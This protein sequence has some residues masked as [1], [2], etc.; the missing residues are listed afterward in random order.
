MAKIAAAEGQFRAAVKLG[1]AA[2]IISQHRVALQRRTLETMAKIR[3]EKNSSIILPAQ[4]MTKVQE[5]IRMIHGDGP[6]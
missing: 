2:D 1:E 3:L 5:A 6:A 4:F